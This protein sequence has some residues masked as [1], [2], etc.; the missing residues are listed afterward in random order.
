MPLYIYKGYDFATGAARKG[1]VEA[2]SPKAARQKLRSKDN[3]IASEIREEVAITKEKGVIKVKGKV[4]LQDLSIMTRQFSTL[5]SAHVPLDESLKALTDQVENTVLRNALAAV[6]D[7]V[8]EGKSLGEAMGSFP[9]IFDR[10]YVNMVKAGES[11]GSLG[12]VLERLADFQEYQV[13]VRGKIFSALAYPSLMI[14]ASFGIII[15][16]FVSV[17]P[18]LQKVFISLKVALPWYTQWLINIS[19]FLQAKWYI[20][21][22]VVGAVYYL[23]KVW[24]ASEAG[25]E[26]FDRMALKAPL[27]G[28]IVLRVNVSKFTKT[29]STL[30][31]SGVPIIMALEITKNIIGNKPISNAVG[32][33][34]QAVQE[35]ESLAATIEKTKV[36]PSLVTHMIRTGEKTGELEE[37]LKHVAA[38]YDSEVERK[39][40]SLL[41]LIEPLMIILMGGIVVVV[42][43]AMLVPMLSIMNQIRR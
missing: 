12:I 29:L 31:G 16:L 9:N 42:V 6:K 24:Y 14:L 8:S 35:G 40:E 17:V 2:D 18:K 39:I 15:Y 37:M 13:A 34:R 20:V 43:I 4:K 28:G 1:K 10:L 27:F 7:M 23:F 22:A 11:S 33:A 38:A 36:F 26:S 21:V 32:E 5:Q 3:I 30:L 25:R 19:E 41:S